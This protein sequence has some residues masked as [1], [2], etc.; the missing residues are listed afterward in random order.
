[1]NE[2]RIQ[3]MLFKCKIQTTLI[4]V[5]RFVHS[6]ELTIFYFLKLKLTVYLFI[7]NVPIF[8]LIYFHFI[9]KKK[10]TGV[11]CVNKVSG[12]SCILHIVLGR[13]SMAIQAV[14]DILGRDTFKI[15][16][17]S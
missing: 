13:P 3:S 11:L 10:N 1:M 4:I 12:R 5:Y 17:N 14:R 6:F 16:T 7:F 15:S 8:I 2:I 9:F